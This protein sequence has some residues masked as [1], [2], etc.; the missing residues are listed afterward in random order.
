MNKMGK[1][2]GVFVLVVVLFL[3]SSN[4]YCAVTIANVTT[5]DVTPSGFCVVW[6]TSGPANPGIKVFSDAAGTNDITDKLEVTPFPLFGGNPD[7]VDEFEHD[8][9]MDA[10]RDEAQT[11]GLMK[12][13]VQGC[14]PNTVY[15][16]RIS[17]TDEQS[18]TTFWPSGD[19]A[20]VTTAAE[21]SFVADSKQLLLTI[22]DNQGTLDPQGWIVTAWSDEALSPVSCYVG[23]GAHFDQAYL[24]LCQL[25]NHSGY[26]WTPVGSKDVFLSIMRPGADPLEH[27]VNLE[28]TSNFFVSQIYQITLNVS[29]LADSDGDGLSD[30]DEVNVYHTDPNNPDTDGDGMPD[31]WEV[32]KG[33]DPLQND[34]FGDKDGDGFPNL[35]EF[36][37]GTDPQNV[38]DVPSNIIVYVD[39][40][41]TSGIENGTVE[42]P[43]NTIQE[44]IDFAGP[45]DSLSVFSGSYQE[46]IVVGKK[47][48]LS[49]EDPKETIID[50][51]GA[52]LP[53]VTFT[54]VQGVTFEGFNVR[55]SNVSGIKCE[56]SALTIKR[57]FVSANK[58]HGIYSD[59]TSTITVLNNVIFGNTLCGVRINGGSRI[60]N[61]TIVGNLGAGIRCASGSGVMI[62]NNVLVNNGSFGIECEQTPA[63]QISFNDVYNNSSGNY[64]GCT[65]GNGD[66]SLNPL[67]VDAG[68]HD[69]RLGDGSPC[70]DSGTSNRAPE[71]DF[72]LRCRFDDP[73]TEPNSGTGLYGFFDMGAYEYFGS[74]KADLNKDDNYTVDDLV[75]FAQQ[76]GSMACDGSCSADLDGDGDVDGYDLAEFIEYVA[77]VQCP[78]LR[79]E[80]D[81]DGDGDVDGVDLEKI[82][83]EFGRND[84]G[85]GSPCNSDL[86]GDGV[87]DISDL[88]I[89][90]SDF[91][92]DDCQ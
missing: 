55:N 10:L 40:D 72:K 6:Q 81:L 46:N 42:N 73:D 33:L 69:Y 83:A 48:D 49:G 37:A 1:Y 90:A 17:A 62:V 29:E 38:T 65:A 52:S 21:N 43:F 39:D 20:S 4:A 34:A 60:I 71:R 53:A 80:G 56:N 47:I 31:G 36:L 13:C 63:P 44:G 28:Y 77:R 57:N 84:C 35:R 45:G 91:G 79:C 66:I 85:A 7:I 89:I 75:I 59:N 2:P 15:Y 27:V 30:D 70:I 26:N 5:A 18:E 11:K 24:N 16:Y 61:N 51:S 64:S 78:N 50:G 82:V 3:W 88:D 8:E 54:S 58:E 67:F 14:L 22:T 32:S 86:N 68:N 87:V 76:F 74:C 41:N 19:L 12:I 25:F 23:D 92:R 9:D